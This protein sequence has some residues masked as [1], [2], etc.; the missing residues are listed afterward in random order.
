MDAA[1]PRVNVPWVESPFFEQEL[2]ARRSSLTDEQQQLARSFHDNGFLALRQAIPRELCDRVRAEAE[3]LLA[4]D[5]ALEERR[6]QDAWARG[7]ESSRELALYKP[8]LELLRVLYE[9]EPIPFQ[10]LD[11]RVGTEQHAHADAVHFSCIPPRYMC[12]VWVALEATDAGNG[13]LFYYPGSHRLP[14]LTMYDLGQTVEEVRY[15]EYEEFQYRLMDQL[16][17]EP[18]EFHAE[19][20]DAFLWASNIIHGGRPVLEEGRTRWSQVSHYYFEGGIYYTPVFSDVATGRLLLK[21]IVDL[22]TM[23]PVAHT[24]NGRPLAIK[25]LPDG[26]ARVSRESDDEDDVPPETQAALEHELEANRAALA[27]AR[28]ALDDVYRSASYRVGHALIEP[29]RRLRGRGSNRTRG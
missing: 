25:K 27:E 11:F 20:G 2:E 23:E 15:N 26:L 24:L 14:E 4:E 19:K 17:V 8:V 13:P 28:Q 21:D 16:G 7:A 3:P 9:R 10:T 12:G 5:R 22:K 18:V 6:V 29:V 1:V